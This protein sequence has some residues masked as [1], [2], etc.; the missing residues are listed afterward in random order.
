MRIFDG[1]KLRKKEMIVLLIANTVVS[2]AHITKVDSSCTVTA[3][4]EQ[5]PK[6]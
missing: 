4:A 3:N 6:T 2:A 1:I 5:I